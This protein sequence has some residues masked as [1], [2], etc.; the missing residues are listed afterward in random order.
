M[1]IPILR[2]Y[3]TPGYL[4][5]PVPDRIPPY[6][7][8]VNM[9]IRLQLLRE[10][11]G[12]DNSCRAGEDADLCARAARRGWAQVF[13]P[14]AQAFHEPRKTLGALIRQWIWYGTG[15][16]HFLFKQQNH[17]LEIFLNME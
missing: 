17:R 14:G 2:D 9:A 10:I 12:Y 1:M 11:G 4:P 3:Y 6:L 7:P 13:A 8:N 5:D 16:S 15:G